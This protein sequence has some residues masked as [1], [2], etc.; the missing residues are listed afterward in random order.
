MADINFDYYPQFFTATIL[1]WKHPLK[2]DLLSFQKITSIHP[3]NFMK[4][5]MTGMGFLLHINIVVCW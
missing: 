1:E 4:Q 3:P 2:E 5:V